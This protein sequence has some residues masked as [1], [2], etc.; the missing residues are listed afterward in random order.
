MAPDVLGTY[1]LLLFGISS[2]QF[3]VNDGSMME[4]TRNYFGR[5]FKESV[6]KGWNISDEL[7]EIEAESEIS[8]IIENS[9]LSRITNFS[10]S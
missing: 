5:Y 7:K 10:G 2:E 6:S 8:M 4:L 1:L 9:V 3:E